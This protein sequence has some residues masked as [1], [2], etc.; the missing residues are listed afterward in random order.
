MRKLAD[1]LALTAV[2]LLAGC[3]T[4]SKITAAPEQHESAQE[5]S[6][7]DNEAKAALD[8]IDRNCKGTLLY[9]NQRRYDAL[10]RV[11]GSLNVDDEQL[12]RKLLALSEQVDNGQITVTQ[13]KAAFAETDAE[14]H[15]RRSQVFSAERAA[16]AATLMEMD[17]NMP[18]W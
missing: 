16:T 3:I 5:N 9:C 7:K 2:F 13:A 10:V 17:M 8:E 12:W 4:E 1:G 11:R 15:A 18:R 6:Q 14:I